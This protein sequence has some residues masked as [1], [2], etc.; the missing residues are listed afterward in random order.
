MV[1]DVYV[2]NDH[3]P[4]ANGIQCDKTIQNLKNWSNPIAY[5]N[6]DFFAK[7]F[8]GTRPN[9]GINQPQ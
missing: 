4:A 8:M 9:L 3:L 6:G 7:H 2:I 1:Y 5:D